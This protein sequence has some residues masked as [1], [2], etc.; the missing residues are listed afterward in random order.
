MEGVL[1]SLTTLVVSSLLITKSHLQL[2]KRLLPRICLSK[3]FVVVELSSRA[4]I[5]IM[6]YSRHKNSVKPSLLKINRL[7]SQASERTFRTP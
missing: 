6:V 2:L 7:V 3:N 5:R 1:F 4:T